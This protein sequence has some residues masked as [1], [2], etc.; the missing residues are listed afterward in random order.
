MAGRASLHG[1]GT[2]TIAMLR[3][4]NKLVAGPHRRLPRLPARDGKLTQITKDHSFVQSLVDEGRITEDEAN[5]TRSA[6]SS[7]GS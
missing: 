1:M 5:G 6:P 4:D 2:T 3:T 7:P